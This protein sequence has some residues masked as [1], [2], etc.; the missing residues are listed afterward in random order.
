[1]HAITH[2]G[3]GW[4]LVDAVLAEDGFEFGW[5][6]RR[7]TTAMDDAGVVAERFRLAWQRWLEHRLWWHGHV[8]AFRALAAAEAAGRGHGLPATEP[9]AARQTAGREVAFQSRDLGG[10]LL[11]LSRSARSHAS[12]VAARLR[13]PADG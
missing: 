6:L 1:M 4:E 5:V 8:T 12:A 11:D 13:R 9:M 2:L 7:T 10:L 3:H